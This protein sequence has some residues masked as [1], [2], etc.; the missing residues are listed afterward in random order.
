MRQIHYAGDKLFVDF[1]GL[2]VPIADAVT[3]EFTNAQVFVS[4]LGASGYTFVHAVLS[5]STRD[6]IDCHNKAFAFY[7]GVPNM[8]VPDNLKAAV[9]THTKKEIK[10]NESY[11]D[12]ARHYGC[13]VV[14]ARPYKPQDKSKAELGVKGVQ[15]WILAK[16]RHRT[17]F[18]VDEL[19]EA[20]GR[21]LDDYN[22][23]VIKRFGKSRRQLFERLDA[24]A[25]HNLSL[26]PYTYKEHKRLTVGIDYHVECD[27]NGYSVPYAY[28]GKVV[29]LWYCTEAVSISYKGEIIALHRRNYGIY[30]DSTKIEHMPK[31]HQ[32][33][34]EKWNPKRILNWAGTIGQSTAALMKKIM[35]KRSHPVRGYRSCLAILNFSKH[36]SN[37]ELEMVC[38][39]A[40]EIHAASVSSIESMLKTKTYLI[41][42]CAQPANNTLNSHDNIRGSAYYNS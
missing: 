7:G 18:D 31:S 34:H 41:D 13:T 33:E 35:D 3:G 10:L 22:N 24:P 12:M 39:K 27:G 4:V 1:S 11:K 14:P 23:K 5:Q 17:F 30:E 29:D 2:T 40:L 37:E 26:K 8:V 38:E 19:N 25:L 20:M 6:F 16:L 32:F 36:Y 9:I 21:L 42:E 28:K 15:R